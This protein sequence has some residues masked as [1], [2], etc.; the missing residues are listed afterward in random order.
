MRS[1]P[2]GGAGNTGPIQNRPET[3]AV[4]MERATPLVNIPIA[5]KCYNTH[6]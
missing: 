4:E 1:E 6:I 5:G 3:V 2:G